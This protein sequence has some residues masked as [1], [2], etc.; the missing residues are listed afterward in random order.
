MKPARQSLISTAA[1]RRPLRVLF[2]EDSLADV[3]LC[4]RVL[5]SAGYDL[6]VDVVDSAGEF[7]RRLDADEFD[8]ILS[9]F[10]LPS[11][12]GLDALKTLRQQRRNIPFILV[13]GSL[14]EETAVDAIQL[15]AADFIIKDRLAR[16][17]VAV[18]RVLEEK[19]LRDARARAEEARRLS[20][21][22]FE[23]AFRASPDAITL[24][25]LAE[26]RYLE[27][28]DSFV[29]LSGYTREEVIGRTARDLNIIA[30]P[31]GRARLLEAVRSHGRVRDL[32]LQFRLK[33]GEL[34]LG[35]VSA[36]VIEVAGEQCLLNIARDITERKRAEEA[37]RLSE[38]RY[39][40]LFEDS[41]VS[42]WMEDFSAVKKEIDELR[43]WG[44][45]DF[46]CFFAANPDF[47]VRCAGLIK[48]LDVNSV[49]L[50]LFE[51]PEKELLVASLPALFAP[52]SYDTFQQELLAIARGQMQIEV[53]SLGR[54]LSGRLLH[55]LVRWTVPHGYRDTLERVIVSVFDVTERVEAEEAR[56]E[57]TEKLQAILD[58]SP[59]GITMLDPQ[60]HVRTWNRGA[61]RIFGWSE[62]E[63]LGQF[64]PTIPED[65]SE[66]FRSLM[67]RVLAGE[68][69]TGL[70]LR[71]RRKDGSPLDI[72]LSTAP[73]Y[74]A[75][76]SVAGLV[77]A[78]SDI[79]EQKQLQERL[80]QA[81]KM[82]AVGRLAGGIAHD[83]NN[84]LGVIKGYN[85]MARGRL[86][87]ADPLH[88]LLGE[89]QRAADRAAA[90]TR[91]LL[92]FS[93]RQVL[94][95]RVL[96]LNAVVE[97]LRSMFQRLLPESIELLTALE[98][99]LG[100]V[101][102]DP[103]Q[104]EQ[105]IMNL[106]LNA[107]DAMPHG[108]R[109]ILETRNV[110]L[111][112]S[113]VR[114]HLTATPGPYVLLSV[115][116]TGVGMD[117]ETLAHIFE[118]FFTT[119]EQ[120]KGTGLGLAT[121]YGIVKQSGGY[122]WAY[123]EPGRGSSFKVYLP[124]VQEAAQARRPERAADTLPRGTETVL[125]VEDEEGLRR[126]AREFL[127]TCGYTVLEARDGVEALEVVRHNSHTIHLLLTDVVLPR[128][129]GRDL[130]AQLTTLRPE[131]KVLYMSGY[132]DHAILQNG[133]L[134]PGLAFLQKP[135]SLS[136][137]ATKIRKVL[138]G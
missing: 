58:A 133:A 35:L 27:V 107:R 50:A 22:K 131:V 37:L 93:R 53:E 128:L 67:S 48:I 105:V 114:Q 5:E 61:E 88:R 31:G 9:D 110:E 34:R 80:R 51:S 55:L 36:E 118:P 100:R 132:T 6:S 40:E 62:S 127:E 68:S 89:V 102:V 76:G 134:E 91:Q 130:A 94:E 135:F 74:A 43:A 17:P 98:P 30:E 56:R 83:F 96:E 124:R 77:G 120:G 92:A 86:P 52:A 16:L 66:E 85:E 14:G 65:K 112:D 4:R 117:A 19:T 32:E 15:G 3:E 103:G 64:L 137:L 59:V 21:E 12:T 125:V 95:P 49:S 121:A 126:L 24:T 44:V 84:L 26:G 54:T 78:M 113:Y 70:E 87:A 25:T 18:R 13:T 129:S 69:L 7:A 39:R 72:I 71:R 10:N 1:P 47:V 45:T 111:D 104:L 2:V 119:K 38:A 99:G 106:V 63:V 46:D 109:L 123:S 42:L 115:S 57:A 116:D 29:R 23:K 28:N 82:E 41:P 73:L 122:I 108:G 20:E 136:A 97:D 11:W 75:G 81:Q 79:T 101:K 33:S 90:L 8:V 60:G 138:D